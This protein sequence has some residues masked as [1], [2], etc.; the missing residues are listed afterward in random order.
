M[1]LC[2]FDVL[3]EGLLNI[4]KVGVVCDFCV[5]LVVELLEWS[6]KYV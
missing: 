6:I 2:L 4:L 1:I 3:I 5:L